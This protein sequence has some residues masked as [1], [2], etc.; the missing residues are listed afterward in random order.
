MA[1]KTSK[2]APDAAATATEPVT[3]RLAIFAATTWF[4]KAA[5][6][7]RPVPEAAFSGSYVN[8]FTLPT[9]PKAL[10]TIALAASAV[11]L[12]SFST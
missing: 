10:A 12:G 11:K 7:S 3:K 8:K 2:L 5:V 9:K 1:P 4:C 6:A